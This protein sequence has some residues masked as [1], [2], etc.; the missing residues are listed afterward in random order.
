ML[1]YN[2]REEGKDRG[3][4][5]SATYSNIVPLAVA[6]TEEKTETEEDMND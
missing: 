6:S 4:F 2:G 1:Q 3:I 5:W